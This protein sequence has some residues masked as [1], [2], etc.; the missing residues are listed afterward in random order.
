MRGNIINVFENS[1]IVKSVDFG[2]SK[3]INFS[4]ICYLEKQYFSLPIQNIE[5]RLANI[6]PA[7]D[8]FWTKEC[9]QFFKENALYHSL[10]LEIKDYDDNYLYVQLND[11]E[12]NQNLNSLLIANQYGRYKDLKK[13]QYYPYEQ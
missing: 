5:V 6:I 11:F 8:K 4:N 9:I 1:A 13:N 3:L 7:N 10:A 12:L 2:T